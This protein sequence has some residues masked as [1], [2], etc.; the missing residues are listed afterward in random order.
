MTSWPWSTRRSLGGLLWKALAGVT[1][2]R[3]SDSDDQIARSLE[4]RWKWIVDNRHNFPPGYLS[5][6]DS[7]S[8]ANIGIEV[9]WLRRVSNLQAA[10][11]V[12][13]SVE[14]SEVPS[15]A[16][17]LLLA[18]GI[19]KTR[20]T[21]AN[22]LSDY[23]RPLP[24]D[25][26]PVFSNYALGR[27]DFVDRLSEDTIDIPREIRLP[28]GELV[29]VQS[30]WD[31]PPVAIT[32]LGP[33]EVFDSTTVRVPARI[34]STL[35]RWPYEY[36]SAA[37]H[38]VLLAAPIPGDDDPVWETVY[39]SD[40]D[41]P[42][43][44]YGRTMRDLVLIKGGSHEGFLYYRHAGYEGQLSEHYTFETVGLGDES[45]FMEVE[46]A[47]SVPIPERVTFQQGSLGTLWNDP[48][49]PGVGYRLAESGSEWE[50][51][52]DAPVVR[53]GD[54]VLVGEGP[55][56]AY[57]GSRPPHY[58]L[59]VLRL[60]EVFDD[61]TLRVRLR[62]TAL[63]DKELKCDRLGFQLSSSPDV[64]GRIHTLWEAEHLWEASKDRPDSFAGV[65]ISQGETYEA[66]VYFGD[67]EGQ[68]PVS[69]EP[70]TTLWYGPAL[71]EF[72][73]HLTSDIPL[74]TVLSNNP[75]EHTVEDIARIART[76]PEEFF[77]AVLAQEPDLDRALQIYAAA[78]R[79]AREDFA[80]TVEQ[81]RR[82]YGE[83]RPATA[84][85]SVQRISD[86]KAWV[87]S[88]LQYQGELINLE[89]N[90]VVF[91]DGR[92]RDCDCEQGRIAALGS[93]YSVPQPGE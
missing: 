61:R 62:V 11:L 64:Y 40:T 69:T 49:V 68:G 65:E 81:L 59:T 63:A 36:S 93:E 42:N 5:S 44:L 37:L 73:I 79:P 50:A 92:W 60:P 31:E 56:F 77:S 15:V 21:L 78:C 3:I 91:E 29:H 18:T 10:A 90:L 87:T 24:P 34:T 19:D 70:F 82:V 28:V 43:S 89:P 1:Q 25:I 55:E 12:R 84:A 13:T 57:Q 46:F 32:I 4:S 23:G 86:D 88:Q 67:P 26:V 85:V 47:R 35:S 27:W 14:A 51:Q 17:S 8:L 80:K 75:A 41:L 54:I 22:R 83:D 48:P 52:G 76:L 39:E 38:G 9:V 71:F 16:L 74:R 53:I 58:E 72:P 66:F 7:G 45:G 20:S 33:P 2:N 30:D 6:E